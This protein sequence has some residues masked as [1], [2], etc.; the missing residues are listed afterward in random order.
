VLYRFQMRERE[1]AAS[2]ARGD[3]SDWVDVP[4]RHLEVVDGFGVLNVGGADEVQTQVR[5]VFD[6][7]SES[8]GSPS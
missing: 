1:W 7:P 5:V 3:W 2:G 8:A 4:E 6:A